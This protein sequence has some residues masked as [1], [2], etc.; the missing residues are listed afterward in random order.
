MAG[1]RKKEMKEAAAPKGKT[2]MMPGAKKHKSGAKN[3]KASTKQL[4][5]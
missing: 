2:A 1:K 5:K 4:N 3:I